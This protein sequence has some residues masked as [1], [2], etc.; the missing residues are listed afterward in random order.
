M[1]ENLSNSFLG[2]PGSFL[3]QE[4]NGQCSMIFIIYIVILEVGYQILYIGIYCIHTCRHARV[5]FGAGGEL[6]ERRRGSA[7][8]MLRP[9]S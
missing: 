1:L 8:K 2:M 7:M 6:D 9:M 3:E 4:D 5:L